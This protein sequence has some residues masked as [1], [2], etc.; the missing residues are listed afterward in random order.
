MPIRKFFSIVNIVD[1]IKEAL[2]NWF[3]WVV[4]LIGTAT[5]ILTVS[6]ATDA[7]VKNGIQKVRLEQIGTAWVL[8]GAL[9]TALGTH[10]TKKDKAILDNMASQGPLDAK[11]IVRMLKA[12]SNFSTYGAVMIILGTSVLVYK[13][14]WH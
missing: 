11:E 6:F 4:I 9:W 2:D 10:L 8:L 7:A 5:Y 14:L 3:P 1:R 12:A 13:M